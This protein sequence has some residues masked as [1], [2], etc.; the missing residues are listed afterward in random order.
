MI[1][2][3]SKKVIFTSLL[4][5]NYINQSKSAEFPIKNKNFNSRSSELVNS[6]ISIDQT[7][8]SSSKTFFKNDFDESTKYVEIL[9]K[10]LKW[11][12]ATNLSLIHI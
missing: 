12:I 10:N 1:L 5:F 3:I 8:L 11:H 4:F 6:K 7:G 9:K 2:G